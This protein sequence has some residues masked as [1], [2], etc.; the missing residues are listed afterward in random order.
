MFSKVKD[1]KV[2]MQYRKELKKMAEIKVYRVGLVLA[3]F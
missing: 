1:D 2:S 3:C